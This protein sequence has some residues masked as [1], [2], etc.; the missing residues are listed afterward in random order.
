MDSQSIAAALERLHPEPPLRLDAPLL[1]AMRRVVAAVRGSMGSRWMPRVPDA[2][3]TPPSAE[4]FHR[5][6][7][8]ALGVPLPRYA[9]EHGGAEAWKA[10]WPAI[11]EMVQLLKIEEGPF[12]MGK[13]RM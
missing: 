7:E 4:Y 5:T 2:V 8:L 12:L 11:A 9:E 1:P 13:S 10:A 6:R 3:L